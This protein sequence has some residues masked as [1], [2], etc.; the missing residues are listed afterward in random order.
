MPHEGPDSSG[1]C[2]PRCV[3]F[4][5]AK[6]SILYRGH[7]VWCSWLNDACAGPSCSYAQ[8][9]RNKLLP[10]N[11]CGLVIRR[12]TSDVVKPEDFNLNIKLKGKL[13]RKLEGDIV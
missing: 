4:K 1:R 9:V 7:A 2:W 6:K 10:D 13:A 3:S 8:C 11:R 5:C 12:I